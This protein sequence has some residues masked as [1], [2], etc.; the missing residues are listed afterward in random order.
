LRD[1]CDDAAAKTEAGTLPDGVEADPQYLIDC[2]DRFNIWAESLGAFQKGEA[3]LDARLSNH[4][5]AREVVRL[6]KQLHTVISDR[7]SLPTDRDPKLPD[8]HTAAYV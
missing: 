2:F 8:I 3:S 4:V 6:L 7:E 5:L 1:L